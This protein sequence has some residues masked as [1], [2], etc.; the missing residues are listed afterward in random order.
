M[1]YKFINTILDIGRNDWNSIVSDNNP[2]MNYDFLL[3]LESSGCVSRGAG[4]SP[5]HLIIS[6]DEIVIA[7]M[8]LYLKYNSYGE[9]IFDFAWAR[10][11]E[12]YG[13]NYYPKLLSAIPFVPATGTRLACSPEVDSSEVFLFAAN[14][15][16]AAAV[17]KRVSSIH[18]LLPSEYESSLWNAN[19]LKQK[20][21]T[22]FHW[23]NNHYKTFN[24]FL[25]T[26][27]SRKRKSVRKERETISQNGIVIEKLIGANITQGHWNIFYEFYCDTYRK[28]SGHDGY[29]NKEF[30][31]SLTSSILC[32]TLLIFARRNER[33]V[34]GALY[35]FSDTTLYGRHWG[36]VE[37][38]EML[39]FELC[40]YSGIEFCIE[41]GLQKFEAGAQGEHKVQRGFVPKPVYSN[42]WIL[43]ERFKNAV[44]GHINEESHAN[45]AYMEEMRAFLPFKEGQG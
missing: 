4:W 18:I 6:K 27:N 41:S 17:E 10:A 40:Y 26:F 11:Y 39:H 37:E 42:H 33:Y 30:F 15:L 38:V 36:C 34:A 9:Y 32:R 35:F 29:L 8:P 25:D 7:V 24:E 2:F 20:I 28:R 45:L 13:V 21:T 5:H 3:A 19:G 23:F 43:D 1:N 44:Y 22:Q 14:L 12:Q 31:T 16:K